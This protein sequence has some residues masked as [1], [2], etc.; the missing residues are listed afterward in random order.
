MTD[1]SLTNAV[2]TQVDPTENDDSAVRVAVERGLPS[3]I[4]ELCALVR[5]PSVA[6]SAFDRA[7]VLQSAEAVAQLARDLQV[8]DSV[9]IKQAGIPGGDELGQPAVLATRAA[10]NGRPTV[11]LYAHHDVQPP[12]LDGDWDSPPFEPTVRGDRLYGRGAAD[13]KAG[14]MAH[15]ASIRALVEAAGSDFELGLAL[16]IEGEEEFG[17]RSFATFLDE[18]RDALR[19]DVI[20]VADS[21]N[22]DV[23]TPALTTGLRGNVTLRLEV[24][25][26]DHASH[27]GM[28][29]GAVPDAMMATITL[30]A[31]LYN[32]DGS[33][34][35]AGLTSH[36]GQTPDYSEEQLRAETGLLDGVSPIGHG[37]ILS[38]IWSQPAITV[39]GI[40]APSVDNAS[41][42]LSPCITVRL[43]CRIAPG[44]KAD[45]AAAALEAH[46]RSHA[47]FGA[48]I[49][50]SDVDC[51]EPFLVE[52][53]GW[54]V[55]E[56]RKAMNDAWGV[57]PVDI[58]VGGSIPFISDLVRVFPEA[59]ILVTGVEDPD[60]RAHS[61]NESLHLGVF[62][63]A[64]LSESLLLARLNRRTGH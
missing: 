37:S 42:T 23:S 38:R 26:L 43:S 2:E 50:I 20:V 46:L 28:F 15:I 45:E 8:F 32:S 4:A 47:P 48:H 30:L 12:G 40:D 44:Q 35:V 56:A 1:N 9:Q 14:V 18:N 29:G 49:D 25:T 57:A 61:P 31:T 19:G 16:F 62:K 11:L 64:V 59:Q 52:T 36:P 10:R 41:N 21:N 13:D 22:W 27:S 3:T 58:G 24:R 33:V 54:A 53:T 39:T 63:R 17:S 5:I 7:T 60:S 34:A 51:G 55:A 6:W